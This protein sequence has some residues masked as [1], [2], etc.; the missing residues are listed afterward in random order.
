MSVR[1][2]VSLTIKDG[3]LDAFRAIAQEMI[4]VTRKESGTLAYE[5]YFS[6]DGKRC[7]LLET[8]TDAN[9]VLAHFN[10]PAVKEFVPKLLETAGVSEFE[11]YGDPGARMTEMLPAFGAEIFGFW[12]GL[13]K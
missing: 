12:Q 2:N 13:G 1:L 4:A 7:R 8:Y 9:A 11:V 3:K 10:G 5:W 6:A